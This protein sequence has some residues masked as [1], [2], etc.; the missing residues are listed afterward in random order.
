MD[1]TNKGH[2]NATYVNCDHLTLF[3][4]G[5]GT[6][7]FAYFIQIQDFTGSLPCSS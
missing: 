4:L 3:N 7:L 2:F 1:R 6:F 5:E